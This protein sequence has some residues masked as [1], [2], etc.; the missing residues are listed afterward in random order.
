MQK[1]DEELK[2]AFPNPTWQEERFLRDRITFGPGHMQEP[3]TPF[4]TWAATMGEKVLARR[5]VHYR[6]PRS[7]PATGLTDLS[8]GFLRMPKLC[9]SG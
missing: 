8:N 4:E 1:L 3:F 9:T 7:S 2:E 6:D 5:Q